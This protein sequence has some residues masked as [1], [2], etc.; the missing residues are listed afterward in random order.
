[1]IQPGDLFTFAYRVD[2]AFAS[3]YEIL[4]SVLMDD[5]IPCGGLCLCIGTKDDV[6]H[7]ISEH[8]IFR[9]RA[10]QFADGEVNITSYRAGG[11]FPR[12]VG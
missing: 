12:K 11:V 1:M 3:K 10:F 9:V 7:W 5:W 4:C 6:I 2:G 8:G